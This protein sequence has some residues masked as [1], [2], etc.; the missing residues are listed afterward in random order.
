MRCVAGQQAFAIVDILY[1]DPNEKIRQKSLSRV[2]PD[3]DRDHDD[4]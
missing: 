4:R 2:G 1:L 3:V